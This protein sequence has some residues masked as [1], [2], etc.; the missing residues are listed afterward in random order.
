MIAS[1][2][3]I[4]WEGDKS[5]SRR[6][7][8]NVGAKTFVATHVKTPTAA[9]LIKE[10]AV[11]HSLA[12]ASV[13][14]PGSLEQASAASGT[15]GAAA[16]IGVRFTP[17]AALPHGRPMGEIDMIMSLEDKEER[18]A[19]ALDY[20]RD[21]R[22][23]RKHAQKRRRVETLDMSSTLLNGYGVMDKASKEWLQREAKNV[24]LL[25]ANS[26]VKHSLSG[27]ECAHPPERLCC[28]RARTLCTFFKP[29]LALSQARSRTLG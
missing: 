21:K 3:Q 11:V 23:E 17:S 9:A 22:E 27:S 5:N 8:P 19:M 25:I 7:V 13:Q 2:V 14:P 18:N 6:L 28:L 15:E 24:A 29:A 12:E 20:L 26:N 4:R 1:A 16:A 10:M